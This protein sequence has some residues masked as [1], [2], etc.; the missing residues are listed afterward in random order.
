MSIMSSIISLA[1]RCV[2]LRAKGFHKNPLPL[3]SRVAAGQT[4]RGPCLSMIY[5]NMKFFPNWDKYR[6]PLSQVFA[7]VIPI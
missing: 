4:L 2:V 3:P 7:T 5:P 6:A 1:F